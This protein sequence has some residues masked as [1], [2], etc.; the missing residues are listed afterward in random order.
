L[1]CINSIRVKCNPAWRHLLRQQW[2]REK[3][4]YRSHPCYWSPEP[5]SPCHL[6]RYVEGRFRE[7]APLTVERGG[8]SRVS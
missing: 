3:H 6:A 5:W 1:G 2:L 4:F 8:W 7:T